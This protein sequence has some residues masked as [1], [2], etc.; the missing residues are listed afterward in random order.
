M[1]KVQKVFIPVMALA[2]ALVAVQCK[3]S[4]P[5]EVEVSD[6][7]ELYKAGSAQILDVRTKQEYQG[8]HVPNSTLI[9]L[10]DI[11]AQSVEIP[12]AKEST[13]YVI[14]RSGNRSKSAADFLR[15]NGYTK[16]VSIKG[17]IMQ[18]MAEGLPV[19]QQGAASD[20]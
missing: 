13:I 8:A 18:W 5:S 7:V 4:N 9:T 6:V 20:N 16:A 12:F 11:Y 3:E 10:Q 17:G 1:I 2:L 19:N 15:K 14:C